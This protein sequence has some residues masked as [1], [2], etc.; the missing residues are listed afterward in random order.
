MDFCL[1]LYKFSNN[2]IITYITTAYSLIIIFNF[3]INYDIFIILCRFLYS[4]SFIIG[5]FNLVLLIILIQFLIILFNF[6]TSILI[7]MG[8][9]F[10][11]NKILIFICIISHQ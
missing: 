1:K 5:L 2:A 8:I 9:L 3:I 11:I 10:T 6:I 7:Y 4:F